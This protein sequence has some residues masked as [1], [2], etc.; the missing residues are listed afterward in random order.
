MKFEPDSKGNQ[1][2]IATWKKKLRT[3]GTKSYTPQNDPK[4]ETTL[5]EHESPPLP[6]SSTQ[7]MHVIFRHNRAAT[8]M[9]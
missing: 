8:I 6:T 3:D 1:Q 7:R 5:R 2:C 9:G 4:L